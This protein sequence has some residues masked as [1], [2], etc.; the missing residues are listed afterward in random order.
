MLCLWSR[1]L[2]ERTCGLPPTFLKELAAYHPLLIA[3]E[4]AFA[5]APVHEV[6]TVTAVVHAVAIVMAEKVMV[7]VVV[8]PELVLSS[9]AAIQTKVA[10]GV[11]DIIGQAPVSVAR[12]TAL[13]Q[14]MVVVPLLVDISGVAIL[15]FRVV[16]VPGVET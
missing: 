16:I 9:V 12:V 3:V 8:L 14:S 2:S 6:P 15:D 10:V 7:V 13:D 5:L 1:P 4:A 11:I